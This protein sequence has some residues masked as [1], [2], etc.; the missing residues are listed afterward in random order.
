VEE[1]LTVLFGFELRSL[2]V[3]PPN[4]D[5]LFLDAYAGTAAQ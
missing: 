1:A 4:L 5:E 2:T 3:R